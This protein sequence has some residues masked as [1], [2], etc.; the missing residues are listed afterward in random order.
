MEIDPHVIN[1]INYVLKKEILSFSFRNTNANLKFRGI[2]EMFED[3][4]IWK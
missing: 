3:K 4:K 2:S 1:V